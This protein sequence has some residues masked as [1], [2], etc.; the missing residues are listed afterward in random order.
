MD[1]IEDWGVVVRVEFSRVDV[2]DVG[3]VELSDGIG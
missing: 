1:E 3:G 2:E